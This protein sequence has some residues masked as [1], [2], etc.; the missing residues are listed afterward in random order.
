MFPRVRW[1][2][3]LTFINRRDLA[4]PTEGVLRVTN[5][6]VILTSTVMIMASVVITARHQQVWYNRII[7]MVIIAVFSVAR[8]QQRA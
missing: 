6:C 7:S 5:K 8:I 4:G 3:R 1:G 2:P